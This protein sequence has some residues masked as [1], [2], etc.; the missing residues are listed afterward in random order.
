MRVQQHELAG[1]RYYEVTPRGIDP[2]RRLPTV[3][4]FHGRASEPDLPT[5]PY[6]D[7]PFGYRTILPEAPLPDGDG[8]SWITASGARGDS[9]ALSE[10]LM[11]RSAQLAAWLAALRGRH[12]IQG[13]PIVTGFSQGAELTYALALHHP[14]VMAVALPLS[15][16]VPPS[17][18]PRRPEAGVDY[19]RVRALHGTRDPLLRLWRTREGVQ[20]LQERGFEVEL[21]EVRNTRHEVSAAMKQVW[22]GWLRNALLRA[23]HGSDANISV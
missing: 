9:A 18:I 7:L 5:R 19:P 2:R 14:E 3:V 22:R 21:L 6:V 8:R 16:Y 17:I 10:G 20:L 12:R 4:Y 11:D 13:K 1:I 15:G 23:W